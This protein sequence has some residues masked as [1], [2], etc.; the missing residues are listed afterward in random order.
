MPTPPAV[1][2]LVFFPAA[3]QDFSAWMRA[4][5]WRA[6]RD[7]PRGWTVAGEALR[8]RSDGNSVLIVTKNGFPRDIRST[9]ILRLRLKVVSVPR[10]TDLSRKKGDDAA[11]RVYAAFE[12]GGGMIA[13]P[14]TIGYTWTEK[15]DAGMLIPSAHYSNLY[16]I[17]LGKGPTPGNEW[18]VVERDLAADYRRAFP[19]DRDLP[20]L[21]GLGLKC[22]TN[23]TKTTAES[24]L[25]AVEVRSN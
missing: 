9:P 23:D 4:G 25:S 18:V 15:E 3:V 2:P 5:G 12:R 7:Q 19:A 22:D 16:Y 13:P 6:K 14:N 8:M 24:Y 1:S 11:L 20:R 10:G 21:G 17:S